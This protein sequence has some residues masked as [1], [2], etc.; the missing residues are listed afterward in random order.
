[1]FLVCEY[2][3]ATIIFFTMYGTVFFFLRK[4]VIILAGVCVVFFSIYCMSG[5]EGIGICIV[6]V[7]CSYSD[8]LICAYL[9]T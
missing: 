5:S 3:T 1:M 4:R 8:G 2:L 9:I 7:L 6:F